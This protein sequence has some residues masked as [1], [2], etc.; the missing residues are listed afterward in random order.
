[1]DE[2]KDWYWNTEDHD[3]IICPYCGWEYIPSYEDTYIGDD[4]VDCFT[5]DENIYTC[6]RCGKKFKMSDYTVWRY[7]TET[8]DGEATEEEVEEGSWNN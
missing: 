1:M 5:E 4:G 2:N 6:D 3:T 7:C 8:I